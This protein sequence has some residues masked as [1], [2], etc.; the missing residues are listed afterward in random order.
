MWCSEKGEY[1]IPEVPK[2]R[3]SL[4]QCSS[5]V[6]KPERPVIC[7]QRWSSARACLPSGQVRQKSSHPAM[8]RNWKEAPNGR[9]MPE[10]AFIKDDAI[11][12]ATNSSSRESFHERAK[13]QV[14]LH[15]WQWQFLSNLQDSRETFIRGRR[16]KV[17][18]IPRAGACLHESHVLD[19]Y[20]TPAKWR[21]WEN[22]AMQ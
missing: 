21:K 17:Q 10:H 13:A 15:K 16:L 11:R 14:C 8:Y 20:P 5:K 19:R 18:R 3:A 1:P 7:A 22:A 9:P 6:S 2:A 12:L 4:H